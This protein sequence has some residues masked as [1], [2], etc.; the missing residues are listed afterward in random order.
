MQIVFTVIMTTF[1]LWVSSCHNSPTLGPT[2]K[3]IESE[4]LRCSP[5]ESSCTKTAPS[6]LVNLKIITDKNVEHHQKK[7]KNAHCKEKPPLGDCEPENTN[8]C[9]GAYVAPGKILTAAHCLDEKNSSSRKRFKILRIV[10]YFHIESHIYTVEAGTSGVNDLG[11]YPH[12]ALLPFFQADLV[13]DLGEYSDLALLSFSQ[14]DLIRELPAKTPLPIPIPLASSIDFTDQ[15]LL[16]GTGKATLS[17]DGETIRRS[18]QG[19]YQ[20]DRITIKAGNVRPFKRKNHPAGYKCTHTSRIDRSTRKQ[21]RQREPKSTFELVGSPVEGSHHYRG[22]CRGDSG[23][24]ITQI[25]QG[26]E[27]LIGLLS[28][29]RERRPFPSKSTPFKCG[30]IM[31]ASKIPYYLEEYPYFFRN[32][33]TVSR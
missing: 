13:N 8:Y 29:G 26:Q 5:Q 14:T 32:M 24:P 22:S 21:C 17:A 3:L 15:A 20:A 19:L 10:V 2:L 25:T 16:Y 33:R 11:E 23:S 30:S 18:G 4:N 27:A 31:A 6:W 9:G 1:F 28:W 12:L 7:P